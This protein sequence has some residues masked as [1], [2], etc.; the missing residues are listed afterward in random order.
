MYF[1]N[2]KTQ[3]ILK[4]IIADEDWDEMSEELS[5]DYI[6]DNYFSELKEFEILKDRMDMLI[7]LSFMLIFS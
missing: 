3:L 4:G 6:K 5:I 2:L 7:F 1:K